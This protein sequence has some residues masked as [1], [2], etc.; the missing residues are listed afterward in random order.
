MEKNDEEKNLK[1]ERTDNPSSLERYLFSNSSY[2]YWFVISLAIVTALIA[3]VIPE[4]TV[5]LVYLRNF[6][7]I[8]FV[9]FLPGF[10][11]I[12]VIFPKKEIDSIE[13]TALSIGMSLAL[14]PIMGLLLTY[15]PWGIRTTP[16]TISLLA[17]TIVLATLAIIREYQTVISK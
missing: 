4:N 6:L 15:T 10:S 16:L 7:G 17:L 14:V 8:V 12:K 9:L 13:R 2:W 5:P 1:T 3:F 11:L